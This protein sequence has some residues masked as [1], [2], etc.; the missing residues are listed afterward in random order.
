MPSRT[1]GR[2]AI[3]A[4][5]ACA[6]LFLMLDQIRDPFLHKDAN[7][8]LAR[9]T[10]DKQNVDPTTRIRL[11]QAYGKLPM[12]FEANK[13]QTDAHVKFSAR[14]AGYAVFLTGDETVLQLRKG[15]S[16]SGETGEE[17]TAVPSDEAVV[18]RMKLADSDPSGQVSGIGKLQTTSNYFIGNDPTA[19]R[20]GI[21]N[22]SKVKYESVYPGIDLIWYGNQHLLEHDFLIAPGSDPS[23]IKLS[24]SGADSMTIDDEGALVLRTGG[25]D[26]R[27]LK[28]IAWQESNASRLTV[29][30][31]YR[32]SD[33]DQVEFRLGD[34][35]TKLPLV[36]DPVLVYSTYIGGIG[37]DS[38]LDITVDSEGAAYICGQTGVADFPG[39]SPIQPTIG[40]SLDAYVLKINPAGNA[41]VFGSWIGGNGSEAATAVSVDVGGN[42]Y[43]AGSTSSSNF[44]LQNPLQTSRQG[45]QDA[46]AVKINSSGSALLYSTYIG[47]AGADSAGA[48]A[49][50]GNGN[51]YLTGATDS[52]DF[53]VV[54]AFQS[55]RNGSGSYASDNRGE[56]WDELDNGLSGSDVNDLVIFPGDSSTI[57]AGTDRGVFK[58]VD[59][60]SSWNLL[61]GTQFIR[62]ISQVIVAPANPDIL[63]AVSFNQV[64]KSIDGGATWVPK[65]ISG[66]R[67]LAI[68]PTTP[69]TLY[70]GTSGGLFISMNGGDSWTSVFFLPVESIVIDP[71]TPATIYLGAS[72]G[73]VVFK[74]INV[75][76]LWTFA[77]NGLPLLSQVRFIRIA[78]SRSNPAT[79]FALADN[80]TIF[81]ST[82]SGGNWAQLN[83][84]AIGITQISQS[85]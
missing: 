10:R 5:I 37:F 39:P 15:K 82:N 61:G 71:L 57:F 3:C 17:Q 25:E 26:L 63:Y 34:Y 54:N 24:F 35:D 42:V 53:P 32:L 18:L 28:P 52:G 47:G 78:I 4:L 62:N 41:I 30:C 27:L 50:D 76:A 56:S 55:I 45:P 73:H 85:P 68:N 9:F 79:L 36:I 59:R 83:T 67:M 20:R 1:L 44:P 23:R 43:L 74:S 14:G 46:F 33:K 70:A 72:Q 31:D 81:K 7:Y 58:S 2:L 65:P 51:L 13:G 38:G 60:G 11:E 48:Q 8:S 40:Q 19:W 49:V 12:R 29:N 16:K 77:G 6:L 75:G 66:V 69:S 22:Y 64:S 84:P 21:A 80:A